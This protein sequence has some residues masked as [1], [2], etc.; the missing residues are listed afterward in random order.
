MSLRPIIA[1][2]GTTGVGKSKLAIDLAQHI[3]RRCSNSYWRGAKIINADAMQVYKGLDIITNKVPEAEQKGVPHHL[4]GFKEPGEQYVVGE[5][6]NDTMKLIDEMHGNCEIP[7]VVGGTSYWVQHLLFPD[8]LIPNEV[9]NRPSS[10]LFREDDDEP[11]WSVELAES[12][13]ALPQ[14]L[15][16]IFQHLPEE[17]PS[18]KVDP[19]A[20]FQL[21]KLLGFLDPVVSQRWHWK[22]TRKVLRNLQIIQDTKRRPSDIIHE[23]SSTTSHVKPRYRTLSF[24][25]FAESSALIPRLDVRVDDMLSQGLLDEV[26]WMK[27]L[28]TR[29]AITDN[30]MLGINTD[31]T[32]GIFQSIGY[33][34]FCSYLDAPNEETY[35]EAVERMKISTRQYAKRQV[36]WIRN[37]L[38]PAVEAA[39]ADDVVTPFYLLDASSLGDLWDLNVHKPAANILESV[40]KICASYIHQQFIQITD[41]LDGKTLPDPRSLSQIAEEKL[42]VKKKDVDPLAVLQARKRRICAICTVEDARPIMIE[43]GPEWEIHQRTKSHRRLA[44]K[45]L[46]EETQS[47]HKPRDVETRL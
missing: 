7:I 11:S 41:F 13:F 12:I 36:S 40:Y 28:A 31:Y 16:T 3:N 37:K 32:L 6:V 39:N 27:D 8:R 35:Q 22:D 46:R 20:A 38:I 5:W 43:E 15:L 21:H 19:D 14:E 4:M 29:K 17:P 42:K 24:W 10:P 47:E 1:I 44:S 23:Q 18:A 25:L 45:R 34:E 9:A 26:R 2:C 30:K 33:R